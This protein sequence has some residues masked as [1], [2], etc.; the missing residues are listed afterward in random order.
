MATLLR[1]DNGCE[2][3]SEGALRHELHVTIDEREQRMVFADAYVGSRMNQSAALASNDA[4]RANDHV[5]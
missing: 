1:R 2:F 4:A 3:V 5:R